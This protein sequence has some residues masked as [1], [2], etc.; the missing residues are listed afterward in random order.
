M[1]N[2]G[3]SFGSPTSGQGF[4]VSSTVS[5]I[6]TN[7][8]AV[9]TP[10]KNQLT[11]LQSQDTALTSIGTDLSSLSTALQS[12]TDFQGVFSGKEGSSSDTS[13]IALTNATSAAVAGTHT[14]VVT[15]TAKT[16]SYAS[17]DISA[18]DTLSGSLTIGG[19]TITISDGTA[20][21]SS[22][23]LIPQNN[24]LATLAAYINAG[25][26]GVTATV[27]TDSSGSRLSLVSNTSGASGSV[28]IA[29]GSLTDSTTGSA[30][31][32]TQA[33]AGQDAMF[34][35][36]GVSMTSG[37]NTVT[38]ALPG[39]TMQLLSAPAG[40]SVQVEITNNNSQ[41]ESTVSSFVDAY[42]TVIKDLNAQEGSNSSGSGEPLY[43][44]PAIAMLQEQ[45]QQAMNFTQSSGAITSLSQLG[46]TPSTSY[47]GT[48]TL[49][50][51]SLDSAL[52]S[53]Y[54]DAMNFFQA[55]GSSTSFGANLS[56]VL[57]NLSN[58]APNGLIYLSLQQNSAQETSLNKNISDQETLISAQKT[59]L[60]TELNQANYTLQEIPQ[61]I[62]YV[63]EIYSAI[64]G[65]NKN[66]N[67]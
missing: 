18:S 65:Y 56:S 17:G 33:Q 59:Q 43:G 35:V 8:Q 51:S 36:D 20:T 48:L 39:V 34:S 3:I 22:G 37:T 66:S 11:A 57:D 15:Q 58:S 64:S 54:Q 23:N 1:G 25:N 12:L 46:I 63:D 32:I 28:A 38:T 2:V 52:N 41:V 26:Y 6:V 13:V 62:Q 19:Q 55:S 10:W 53:N 50:T 7:L 61:Q 30:I 9:E 14:V 29:S 21:D 31:S 40:N 4:D 67:G 45:L 47:D 27:P 16:Y 44:N 49:D 60:T 42:N 5:Q 24:T